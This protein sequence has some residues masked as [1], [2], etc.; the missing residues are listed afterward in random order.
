MF[1][2]SIE[3]GDIVEIKYLSGQDGSM[4]EGKLPEEAFKTKIFNLYDD[5]T[6]DIVMPLKDGAMVVLQNDK[7]FSV[8]VSNKKNFYQFECHSLGRRKEGTFAVITVRVVGEVTKLQRRDSFRMD[9][10]LDVGIRKLDEKTAQTVYRSDNSSRFITSFGVTL[11]I[12]A[13]GVKFI[14]NEEF[15]KSDIIFMEIVFPNPFDEEDGSGIVFGPRR[16]GGISERQ[17][18]KDTFLYC[19][20]TVV[21]CVKND[22]GYF[23][24]RGFF[25]EID[26]KDREK[27]VRYVFLLERRLRKKEV[28]ENV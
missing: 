4:A 1:F 24:T 14:S 15:E 26:K 8:I 2:S 9:A 5:R 6:I 19:L 13:G 23:E 25:S 12:S 17:G 27:I 22:R 20:F 28:E 18:N 16:D 21:E 11:N 10:S 3:E 7:D